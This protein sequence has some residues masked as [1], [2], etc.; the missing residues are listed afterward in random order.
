MSAGKG[1][2]VQVLFA[3]PTSPLCMGMAR[4]V[5][6]GLKDIHSNAV[7][8]DGVMN[9]SQKLDSGRSKPKRPTA[10]DAGIA[11][12]VCDFNIREL[13]QMCIDRSLRPLADEKLSA[14]FD[15]ESDKASLAR[16][17]SR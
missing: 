3:E 5:G 15:D 7:T 10:G 6:G 11:I 4:A 12:V 14:A 8:G 9:A 17:G 13:P 1:Q 2:P 16:C